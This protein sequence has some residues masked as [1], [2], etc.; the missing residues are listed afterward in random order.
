MIELVL[1]WLPD[2]EGAGWIENMRE[3]LSLGDCATMVIVVVILEEVVVDV[4][5]EEQLLYA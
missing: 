5:N 1:S 2:A 3:D 4:E